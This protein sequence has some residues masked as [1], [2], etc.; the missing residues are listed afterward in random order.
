MTND[1]TLE[2]IRNAKLLELQAISARAAPSARPAGVLEATD[3]SIADV[4][5]KQPLVAVDAY[6][7]W[8]GPCKVFAPT[9]ARAAQAHPRVAFV[10]VDVDRNPRFAGQHQIQSIPTLLLFARGTLVGRINGAL[11]PPDL[12]NVLAQ[13]EALPESPA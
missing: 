6:A 11:R 5:T 8:C 12:E 4:V 7:T 1:P 13:L 9:F 3:A 2:A 10:K